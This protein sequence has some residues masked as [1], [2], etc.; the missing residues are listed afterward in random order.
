MVSRYVVAVKFWWSKSTYRFVN[1]T[2]GSAKLTCS[3]D[4]NLDESV[5]PEEKIN[6]ISKIPQELRGFSL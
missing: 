1:S 6:K 4:E 3:G 2:G 5:N